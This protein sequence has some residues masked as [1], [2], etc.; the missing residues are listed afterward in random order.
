MK[1]VAVKRIWGTDG[2]HVV[3]MMSRGGRFS[4][5]C[6]LTYI[7]DPLLAKVFPKGRNSYPLRLSTTWTIVG[8]I[9]RMRENG[10]DENSLVT[11]PHS[12]YSSDFA[13]SDFWLFGHIKTSL[14][15]RVFND[16]D[17]LLD[18][19]IEL[20]NEIQPSELQFVFHHWIERVK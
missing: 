3:D 8:F 7:I 20:S 11:A 15:G 9:L 6:F 14:A 13:P 2:F 16:V 10:F 1:K 12:P 4:T 5:E 18:A 17:E 19:V